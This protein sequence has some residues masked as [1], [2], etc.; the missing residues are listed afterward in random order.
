MNRTRVH[1][2]FFAL[3]AGALALAACTPVTP[4]NAA[5]EKRTI[6]A[7]EVQHHVDVLAA[8]S[9]E[10]R[11]IGTKGLDDAANYIANEFAHSG[12]KPGGVD[13]TWFQ[14][15]EM[16]VGVRLG[17]NDKLTL[18]SADNAKIPLTL[19]DDWRP[20]E[21]S[22]SAEANAPVVFA[23]Y[24]ITAPE[25]DWDD[26]AGLDV[27]GK[28]VLL[29]RHEPQEK[30]PHSKFGGAE[31]TRY[32]ELRVKAINARV[33]GAVGLILVNDVL[34]HAGED[35]SL[36]K[37]AAEGDAS[38]AGIP[39]VHLK[40]AAAD[41]MLS[42]SHLS[43]ERLERAIA[44]ANKPASRVLDN[45]SASIDVDLEKTKKPVKNVIGVLPGVDPEMSKEAVVVGAHYDHLGYGTRDSL[46]PD[47]MG[48]VHNG[49]DDNASGTSALMAIARFLGQHPDG[50]PRRTLI[51]IAFSAEEAGLGGSSFY[52]GHPTWPL[53][54]IVTM[55]NMDMVGRMKD[56]RLVVFG[57]DTASEFHQI[58]DDDNVDKLSISAH[59]DGYGPSDQTAFYGK[60][61]AVLHFFT[62]A[63]SDYHRTTDDADKINSEGLA[64]VARLVARVAGA[65]AD[66]DRRVTFVPSNNIAQAQ[67]Q[68]GSTGGGYGAY[69]GSIP[70]FTESD[71]PGVQIT[72]TRAGSP[73]EKAGLAQGDRIVK[74]GEVT[75]NNLYDLTFALRKYKPGDAIDVVVV[76]G[77]D[78][79]TM[80]ATLE[81]RSE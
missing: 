23:G 58:L 35:D 64:E 69:F 21:F 50:P 74:F 8:D 57:A 37:L 7:K 32:S 10:G 71:T 39:A 42:G 1:A 43:V 28:I 80:K 78:T 54:R 15:F 22:E 46:D 40:R 13:G 45:V 65:L 76:R 72:G 56:K 62:G 19:N 24:G 31:L 51:F 27:T 73:A 66:R 55:L 47:K 68:V 63:H 30:D 2:P 3:A 75:I 14:P 70:D 34:A 49:A 33:H 53:D 5:P 61:I 81:K 77:A 20:L 52:V 6:S 11:G 29:L 36:V 12:L 59:G 48:Q 17:T 25:L 26:Y 79:K 41:R 67:G 38:N 9:M 44:E 18:S 60:N 4:T 16:T